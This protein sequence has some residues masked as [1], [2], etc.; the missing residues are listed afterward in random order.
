MAEYVAR[1]RPGHD[2]LALHPVRQGRQHRPHR[3]AR[4]RADHPEGGLGR[5]RRD[6][7]LA[8]HPRGDRRRD[9][10]LRRRG[11][12]RRGDR[13]HQPARDDRGLGP[14][15]RRA[16]LQR[17]RLAGHAHRRRSCASWPAT[18]ASTGCARRHRPAAL[19]L[20]LRARRSS[21][22][23]TTS[24]AP[25]SGPRTA[26][27]RSAPWTPGCCG[28]SPAAR[29]AASTSPTSPTRSR[30]LLMDLETLDWHEPRRSS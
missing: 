30:T 11:G 7:D 9:G 29:T 28:T 24:T 2:Q 4:A 19:D 8:A 1:D 14:R 3:P 26:S 18:R 21:G 10:R 13:H 12:R 27:C 23:S 16:G 25:A 22:S 17:D 6:R 5:A 15:D 20:L